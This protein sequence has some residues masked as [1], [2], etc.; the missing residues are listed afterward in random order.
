M[1]EEQE[2]QIGEVMFAFTYSQ[3][4]QA[5]RC[6]EKL[7]QLMKPVIVPELD[8]AF[9]QV[10][11][12]LLQIELE[13]LEID[14]GR[15]SEEEITDSLGVRIRHLLIQ[16]LSR[17]LKEHLGDNPL[18]FQNSNELQPEDF[19]LTALKMF[20]LKGYFPAWLDKNRGLY[21]LLED[22]I[23]SFP[24]SFRR[25][26]WEVS[27]R[28]EVARK[29]IAFLNTNFFD[30]IIRILKPEEVDWIIGYRNSYLKIHQ[31][32]S[33]LSGTSKNLEQAL[34]L[35]ILNFIVDDSGT[36]FNRLSFSERSL[37]TIA[38]HYNL[39]FQ[40]FLKEIKKIV[41]K[42]SPK[43]QL[44]RDFKEAILWVGEKNLFA[45]SIPTKTFSPTSSQFL[46]WL[47]YSLEN[48]EIQ[49]WIEELESSHIL[50]EQLSMNFPKFWYSLSERGI[51][52]LI[53][54]LGNNE[55][56]KWQA[57]LQ[58]Y[59]DWDEEQ[60]LSRGTQRIE[61][62]RQLF[63]LAWVETSSRN[64]VLFSLEDWFVIIILHSF[65]QCRSYTETQSLVK[66]GLGQG[67][68]LAPIIWARTIKNTEAGSTEIFSGNGNPSSKLRAVKLDYS[69]EYNYSVTLK[70]RIQELALREYLIYGSLGKKFQDLN[71]HDL[72][73]F[74]S[75]GV[76]E[77]RPF[78]VQL[79]RH[80]GE[81]NDVTVT[82]RLWRLIKNVSRK[83]FLDFVKQFGRE[84]TK[85]L[86]RVQQVFELIWPGNQQVTNYLHAEILSCFL[87][88][89]TAGSDN[90]TAGTFANSL[91]L[92]GKLLSQLSRLSHLSVEEQRR[93]ADSAKALNRMRSY[94]LLST[95]ASLSK[96]T[97]D[98]ALY[99]YLI[100][101][102]A[103]ASPQWFKVVSK[104]EFMQLD[105]RKLSFRIKI[106]FG[107]REVLKSFSVFGSIQNFISETNSDPPLAKKEA[108]LIIQ[109]DFRFLVKQSDFGAV[110]SHYRT[111]KKGAVRRIYLF[112][113]L[114]KE[115]VLVLFQKYRFQMVFLL[116]HF[117]DVLNTKDWNLFEAGIAQHF[118]REFGQFRKLRNS[119]DRPVLNS[120][121]LSTKKSNKHSFS[122][123]GVD[124]I[125]S[126]FT[127][128]R[129]KSREFRET[130]SKSFN[131]KQDFVTELTFLLNLPQ[132]VFQRKSLILKWNR[133]VMLSALK[134]DIETGETTERTN[135]IF[136]DIFFSYLMRGISSSD[137]KG[138]DWDY[139]LHSKSLSKSGKTKMNR[140]F[141]LHYNTGNSEHSKSA[142]HERTASALVFLKEEG[143]LP[144]WSPIRSK[145]GLL[146]VY[147]QQIEYSVQ[148]DTLALLLS[149]GSAEALL[150]GLKVE[151]LK[152]LAKQLSA[153]KHR[154]LYESFIQLVETR[155]SQYGRGSDIEFGKSEIYS[156]DQLG[157]VVGEADYRQAYFKDKP[158]AE[159]MHW[160]KKNIN[161]S[162]EDKLIRT[163]FSYDPRIQEQVKVI[164]RWSSWMNFA[165]L[166]PGK[167]KVLLLTYAFD[168]YIKKEKRF[169]KVFLTEFL[170][171]LNRSQPSVHWKPLF[172]Q[173]LR[174][175]DF[176]TTVENSFQEV[177]VNVF[178]L[179]RK[180]LSEE[181]TTG[182]LVRVSNA[183]LILCWPFLSVL[184]SRLSISKDNQIPEGAQSRAV[185]LLQYLVFGHCE[186]PEY[187]L[188]LNKILVGMKSNQHLEKVEL[189]SEEMEMTESLLEGM[190]SNWDK[191]KNSSI[192]AIRET[193]LQRE[194]TLEFSPDRF[195]LKVPKTGVDVLLDS[196][197]WSIALVRL[198]WM[199]KSLDVKW[200]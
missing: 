42:R 29:R 82:R 109:S 63:E 174:K 124:G 70:L 178:P 170:T 19:A 59:L 110:N 47:N 96:S 94:L 136:W 107:Y 81:I 49:F 118:S 64:T 37:K 31:S 16:A 86:L 18:I 72:V 101:G 188:V 48:Q 145:I 21:S 197:P 46:N 105:L 138:L 112:F 176:L 140:F 120:L 93:I 67:I 185:Y 155:I 193:F 13:S 8:I 95:Q 57:L 168:F 83:H 139:L 3:A 39:D 4:Q 191:M 77:Q 146:S 102:A 159:L 100:L 50:F 104:K 53:R 196:I 54:L 73:D 75:S 167:W 115:P 154:K 172:H 113:Q 190:R 2:N 11:N 6:N 30:R 126:L 43:N 179:E 15:I 125:L 175:D 28:N 44:D 55:S 79:V 84:Q 23:T 98:S 131:W 14:L 45:E 198:P 91:N 89:T 119:I 85:S 194:G 17:D 71:E 129:L 173:L 181:L 143:F 151:E 78:L 114:D 58:N 106:Q 144:W 99:D 7:Y 121:L 180:I 66:I 132:A 162:R 199:E 160:I 186:F 165:N 171:Q 116:F 51:E 189:T 22:M 20:F 88:E 56:D 12:P 111:E 161:S 163:W 195:I 1:T 122:I 149:D 34:N 158:T 134:T 183:G 74:L 128:S 184:F 108:L 90:K 35:F 32:E 147:A 9:A 25:L 87:K 61:L 40:V 52:N 142:I 27:Q 152:R 187:A 80:I 26:I 150:L 60:S 156:I 68:S 69:E 62:S 192:A 182:D 24:R 38:I 169:S 148:A 117:N 5:S 164:M 153:S 133:L 166:T 200:R 141:T 65:G 123:Q 103:P 177:I 33:K 130:L 135:E 36:K 41:L 127:P 92:I 97:F 157:F 76:K 137:L 10:S